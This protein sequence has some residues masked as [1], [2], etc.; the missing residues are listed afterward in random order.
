MVLALSVPAMASVAA[1]AASGSVTSSART[2]PASGASTLSAAQA[3]TSATLRSKKR[4]KEPKKQKTTT[5]RVSTA[6]ANSLLDAYC[7]AVATSGYADVALFDS[8]MRPLLTRG[9][10]AFSLHM[11]D[12]SLAADATA[13]LTTV[14]A[15]LSAS[16]LAQVPSQVR[17]DVQAVRTEKQ[18]ILQH[19]VSGANGD[20]SAWVFI[21]QATDTGGGV[22]SQLGNIGTFL[23]DNCPAS[24]RPPTST[25]AP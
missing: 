19:L 2:A 13:L 23:Q 16:A 24:D 15:S 22:V 18:A 4:K 6:N 5:T 3:T 20:G 8:A 11:S 25:T 17:T 12:P 1:T 21:E 7:H 10:T 9:L 14:T